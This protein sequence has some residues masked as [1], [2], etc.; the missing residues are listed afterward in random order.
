MT[1]FILYF[2]LFISLGAAQLLTYQAG[3]N[4]TL[5]LYF[6]R[7]Y[8]IFY[9]IL[10]YS[11][12]IIIF[13]RHQIIFYIEH[14]IIFYYIILCFVCS[15]LLHFIKRHNMLY[16]LTLENLSW[17]KSRFISLLVIFL[18][19]FLVLWYLSFADISSFFSFFDS[20]H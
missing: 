11:N 1:N 13:I 15:V 4:I 2:F 8:I 6:I 3:T 14:R 7:C 20:I 18:F 17:W 5:Y 10:Y 9:F 16:Y 12:Q 19:Y